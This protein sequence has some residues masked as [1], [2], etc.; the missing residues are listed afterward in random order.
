MGSNLRIEYQEIRDSYLQS[1]DESTHFSD[2]L[3]YKV[4]IH[5]SQGPA[6]NGLCE[7]CRHIDFQYMLRNR[8]SINH[9]PI[10]LMKDMI[11]ARDC[12]FCSL[13]LKAIA[14]IEGPGP[15]ADN[16][17]EKP[18]MAQL[19]SD[20]KVY[21]KS[22]I[23]LLA[24]SR[25]VVFERAPIGEPIFIHHLSSAADAETLEGRVVMQ[26]SIDIP[27]LRRC[28]ELCEK[29]HPKSFG[30]EDDHS[31]NLPTL[32]LIDVEK[33]CIIKGSFQSR[34][35]ALS[36]VWGGLEQLMNTRAKDEE[37]S[38][39]FSLRAEHHHRLLRNTIKDAIL[40]VRLLGERY[41]W[42][43]AL[44]IVQNAPDKLL[45]LATM[46]K[47]YGGAVLTIAATSGSSSDSGLPGV[48]PN[49]RPRKVKQ[50]QCDVQGLKLAWFLPDVSITADA[51]VWN[52]R[53]WTY[54]E[55]VLAQR[56]M[57]V[58]DQ[59]VFFRCIHGQD[60]REDLVIGN[61]SQDM[62][63][64]IHEAGTLRGT[65]HLV[66]FQAYAT[67]VQ[68][69]SARQLTFEWDLLNA[70]AGIMS[71][72]EPRFRSDFIF[73]LPASELDLALL[74]QPLGDTSRRKNADGSP[75][76]PSWSWA[77]WSAG[78][79]YWEENNVIS[80][81]QYK[82]HF[83]G[84][85]I[86]MTDYRSPKS[87]CA[88]EYAALWDHS[89]R[90]GWNRCSQPSQP[91]SYFVHPT[92]PKE[93][94]HAHRLLQDDSHRLNVLGLFAVITLTEQHASN[95]ANI[96]KACTEHEHTICSLT[97]CDDNGTVVGTM[98]VPYHQTG[99]LQS[100]IGLLRL[101]R[102]KLLGDETS[103]YQFG[104]EEVT[105]P[106]NH[107]DTPSEAPEIVEEE[108]L[109]ESNS[110]IST[111]DDILDVALDSVDFDKTQFDQAKPWCI[112]HVMLIAR[113]NSGIY[114]RIGLGKVHVDGFARLH[115]ELKHI[116]LE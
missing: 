112:Y 18:I 93:E 28:L 66:N 8:V 74:W 63:S 39:P 46:D 56:L 1:Y 100:E 22:D 86:T 98:H 21:G 104:D 65:D 114:R 101:S 45:H 108:P 116:A 2:E 10:W 82:D 92:A 76:F 52:G 49:I 91:D 69:F 85:W 5:G 19:L 6:K 32:R 11:S 94:R 30:L 50:F 29:E 34:Y 70:F 60:L 17:G 36:Y 27:H 87:T 48:N 43:D 90:F 77:G 71:Y 31:E 51:S 4:D 14:E 78:V 102:T 3:W 40:L 79:Q 53:A 89:E 88:Q 16:V 57:L 109:L 33:E 47:I 12:G 13:V 41:L 103:V 42:V 38:K 15:P 37:L 73:G 9:G 84:D 96:V 61:K 111:D 97:I 35:V 110:D 106:E 115:P 25:K 81:L 64:N 62:I 26:D 80:C 67:V 24:L 54:Q 58:S 99:L 59:Q 72:F 23:C 75:L 44:C 105:Q 83:S 95:G 20:E 107:L 68:N 113:Q 55:R 7:I